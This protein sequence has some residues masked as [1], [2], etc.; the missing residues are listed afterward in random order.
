MSA[1]AKVLVLLAVCGMFA[2]TAN[3][4]T[5]QVTFRSGDNGIMV[6]QRPIPVFGVPSAAPTYPTDFVVEGNV[7]YAP[8][9]TVAPHTTWLQSLAYD[10]AAQW[11][12]VSQSGSTP[13]VQT[14]SGLYAIMIYDNIT[15]DN[16]T[17][18]SLDI[19]FTADNYV[20]G[21]GMAMMYINGEDMADYYD[22]SDPANVNDMYDGKQLFRQEFEI[23]F[24][25]LTMAPGKNWLFLDATSFGGPA[26]VIF[27]GVVTIP[28][29]D[30]PFPEPVSMSLLAV[31][32][33]GMLIRRKRQA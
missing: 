4:A 19:W 30:A 32:A 14:M 7:N 12:S 16:M 33:A 15:Q 25:G 29:A 21:H 9:V 27:S 3:A 24:S 6:M 20:G 28:V 17:G 2:G 23:H 8:A 22:W 31:G 5:V 11:I 13:G 1:K 10:P 18:V 26:G